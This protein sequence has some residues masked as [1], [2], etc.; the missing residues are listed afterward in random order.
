MR[1]LTHSCYKENSHV[2]LWILWWKQEGEISPAPRGMPLYNFG[3]LNL[4]FPTFS[5]IIFRKSGEWLQHLPRSSKVC[6]GQGYYERQHCSTQDTGRQQ[7]LPRDSCFSARRRP[8]QPDLPGP[9]ELV[10]NLFRWETPIVGEIGY[11]HFGHHLEAQVSEAA[12]SLD[13]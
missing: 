1:S 8:T 5:Q 3:Y 6:R 13:P 2:G 4:L 7:L 10:S 12:A 9:G 11:N